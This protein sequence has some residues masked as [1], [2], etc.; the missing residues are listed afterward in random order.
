M[1][2]LIFKIILFTV[3]LALIMIFYS[4]NGVFLYEGV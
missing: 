1:K 3:M 2:K 4:G